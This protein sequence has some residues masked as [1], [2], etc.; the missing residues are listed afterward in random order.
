MIFDWV[1]TENKG[2]LSLE[3]FSSGLSM[4]LSWEDPDGF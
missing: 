1:D 4:C 3:E 2:C